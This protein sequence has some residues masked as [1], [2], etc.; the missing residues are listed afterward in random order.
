MAQCQESGPEGGGGTGGTRPSRLVM[1][2]ARVAAAGVTR[3][4]TA[5]LEKTPFRQAYRLS[6]RPH[7]V[8]E[9]DRHGARILRDGGERRTT[10]RER[11]CSSR[12]SSLEAG[13]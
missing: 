13:G 8:T 2:P 6:R 9:A 11:N 3:S 7:S 10:E 4:A 12:E 5:S 1:R